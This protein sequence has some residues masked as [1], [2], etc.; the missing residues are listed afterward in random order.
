MR[1]SRGSAHENP[2]S[3]GT[4]S[5]GDCQLDVTFRHAKTPKSLRQRAS[6]ALVLRGF[7]VVMV[8]LVKPNVPQPLLMFLCWGG[9]RWVG[10]LKNMRPLSPIATG[11]LGQAEV[12]FP[13]QSHPRHVLAF[14]RENPPMHLGSRTEAVPNPNG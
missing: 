7:W 14:S 2:Y 1:S 10:P 8:C 11:G 12:W 5:R 13:F 4:S 6:R 9:G 3:D